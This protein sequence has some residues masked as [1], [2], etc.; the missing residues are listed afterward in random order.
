MTNNY[1]VGGGA[2]IEWWTNATCWSNTFVG[3]ITATEVNPISGSNPYIWDYNTYIQQDP[4]V[5]AWGGTNTS[6]GQWQTN[7]GYGLHDTLIYQYY[8]TNNVIFIRTNVY[9]TDR[10]T[11][12]VFNWLSNDVVNVNIGSALPQGANF[13]V[14]N[15]QNYFGL[16]VLTGTYTNQLISLPMTNLYCVPII[17][18]PSHTPIQ[19]WP[20]FGVFILLPGT[21][22][23]DTLVPPANLRIVP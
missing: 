4:Y 19:T 13:H 23:I 7:Y 15:V 20:Q 5:V 9:E 8:P 1:L 14:Q 2:V 10:L 18:I 17:G 22:A 6:L 21:N 16:P 3:A 12:T 11:I